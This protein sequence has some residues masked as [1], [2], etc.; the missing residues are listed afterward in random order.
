MAIH[1]FEINR[2]RN[3]TNYEINI[4]NFSSELL[5][6]L[7]CIIF[8][9]TWKLKSNAKIM[10]LWHFDTEVTTNLI[11]FQT[12]HLALYFS[13]KKCFDMKISLR[14]VLFTLPKSQTFDPRELCKSTVFL[15]TFSSFRNWNSAVESAKWFWF[16]NGWKQAPYFSVRV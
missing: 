10:V 15:S 1:F 5:K 4:P 12:A 3:K 13:M 8:S 9:V 2:T 6:W 16:Q 7:F 11:K 14:P